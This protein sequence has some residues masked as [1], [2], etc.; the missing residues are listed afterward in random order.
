MSLNNYINFNLSLL[1]NW[2]KQ[3]SD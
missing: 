3:Q 2:M 1:P